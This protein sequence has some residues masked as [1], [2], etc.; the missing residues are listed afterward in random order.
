MVQLFV[1]IEGAGELRA[2]INGVVRRTRIQEDLLPRQVAFAT[3][4]GVKKELLKAPHSPGA[5]HKATGGGL[6]AAL[7]VRKIGDGLYTMRPD[8]ALPAISTAGSGSR[9][10]R[11]F[12]D[13]PQVYA[14]FVEERKGYFA[15]GFRNS[16]KELNVLSEKAANKIIRG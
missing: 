12:I 8:P 13:P 7:Q 4:R 5:Y 10:G 15:K 9:G 2:Y 14:N 1:N 3:K 11:G 16:I 6:S